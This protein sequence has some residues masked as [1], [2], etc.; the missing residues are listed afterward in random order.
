[1]ATTKLVR[2]VGPVTAFHAATLMSV[3][4]AKHWVERQRSDWTSTWQPERRATGADKLLPR[5]VDLEGALAPALAP[6]GTKATAV[7]LDRLF[8]VL[9]MP[10]ESALKI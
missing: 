2:S 1:M 9:P 7:L 10:P 8:S 3:S 4:D 5:L 6:A